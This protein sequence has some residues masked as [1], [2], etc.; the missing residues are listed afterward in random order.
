MIVWQTLIVG[1]L[2][3]LNGFF[4][5]SELAIVS[6]K[7]VRLK[8]MAEAGSR[9]ART[10]LK[11]TEDPAD[12][13]STVQV[14]ITL[15]GIFAGAY[16][17]A[18]LS[19]PVA[20]LLGRVP[21]LAAQA[22]LLAFALVVLVTTYLSLMVG[23]LVPKRIALQNP[24]A[25]AA[26][27]AGPMSL[28]ARVGRP[29]V[30]FL[31][32]STQVVLRLLRVPE[33]SG[34]EVTEEEVRA[35]IAEGTSVGV[36]HS[37]ERQLLEGVLRF[38]DRPIRAIMVPRHEM[39]WVSTEEAVEDVVDA[40]VE[41]GHSRFPLCVGTPEEV[42]GIVHV[43]DVLRLIRRGGRELREIATEP[44]FVSESILSLRLTDLFRTARTHMALV[45]DEYGAI[46]GLVTPVDVLTSIAGALPEQGDEP[47]PGAVQREDGSWLMDGGLALDEAA[48]VLEIKLLGAE[49]YSTL[50]GLVLSRLGHIPE[51]GEC[52]NLQ[53]WR[54]EVVDL[55]GRRI[56]KLLVH[57]LAEQKNAPSAT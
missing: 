17:G 49:D 45:V 25:I 53:G 12:F 55:D 42:V 38:A 20:E 2:I 3:V 32:R 31:S 27:A 8:S 33:K 40:M 14:G 7:Q 35:M 26:V 56:D 21:V 24:E 6:A 44:L 54:F 39:V 29:V 30:W 13:L 41:S 46:E 15:I 22:E 28:L 16:G 57:R 11:L 50:A 34:T 1:I 47:P 10:A 52:F 48:A 5:M 51:P 23:E 19:E 18:T 43:K 37:A 36:F 9:G 4:A